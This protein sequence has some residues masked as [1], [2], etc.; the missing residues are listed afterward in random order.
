VNLY[1]ATLMLLAA[2]PGLTMAAE[3]AASPWAVCPNMPAEPLPSPAEA[4][5]AAENSPTYL[6]SDYGEG[7]LDGTYTLRGDVTIQRGPQYMAADQAVYD[8][9]TGAVD[10][11]GG[12]R[13][14][15]NG[16]IAQGETAHLNIK[17]GTGEIDNTDYQYLQQHAHGRAATLI[18][19]SADR[20]LLDH[21]SYSTCDPDHEDWELRARTVTLNHADAVGEA[22]NVTLRL[23]DLPVFYFPYINFPLND[24]RKSGLL[25]PIVGYSNDDGFNLGVPIYWNIA[26]NRDATFTPRFISRRGL[27][28]KGEYRYLTEGS[29]GEIQA[30]L[31]PDDR[32]FGADRGSLEVLNHTQFNPRWSSQLIANYVSDDQ[33]LGD[34]GNSLASASTTEVERRLDLNYNGKYTSF[35][36]RA[37]GYQTLDPTLPVSARPYQRLPQLLF[38]AGSPAYTDGAAYRFDSEYVRFEK[39]ASL[40]GARLNVT[41]A[42]AWNLES[43]GYFF[44]PKIAINHTE[45]RLDGEAPGEPANPDR[46]TPIYS[47]DSGLYL[48]RETHLGGHALLQTLEPRIYYLRI[49]YR[50]QSNLP[51]F[52]TAAY[53][54]SFAQLFRENRFSGADRLGDADQVSVAVTSRLIDLDSGREWLSTSLG[55]ILYLADRRVVLSGPPQTTDRSDLVAEASSHFSAHW[56]T[57]ADLQWNPDVSQADEASLQLHYVPD[58]RHLV[59]AGYRYWRPGAVPLNEGITQTDVSFLWLLSPRWQLLGRWNYSQREHRTLE[60][61]A[62]VQY[63]SCC[64]IIR[65]VNRRYVSDLSGSSSRSLYLQLELKGLGSIGNSPKDILENGI[66][67]YRPGP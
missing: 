27:L 54:F 50:D 19:A 51:L 18:H 49:P 14:Q 26:P 30:E 12:V 47:L 55:Q 3:P 25:P 20:T 34:L 56:S 58:E 36:A 6:N 40:T 67:G 10:A 2:T 62:G 24:Q 59:N 33:Y 1:Q 46:T 65:V 37:Q 35:L 9:K 63:E 8:S 15:Q 22:Y 41:P 31:L 5:H 45:Y 48:E 52:D 42:L 38:S 21:A 11:K 66:L 28:T 43:Q 32:R 29:Q 57:S 39:E 13:F 44:I 64:W 4:A 61:L 7:R 53:D 23:K 60:A 16:L 17:T